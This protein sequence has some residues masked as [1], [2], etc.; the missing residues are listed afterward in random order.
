MSDEL[1]AANARIKELEAALSAESD[2]WKRKAERYLGETLEI[3]DSAQKETDAARRAAAAWKAAAKD[4]RKRWYAGLDEY[5]EL[6][7]TFRA[8]MDEYDKAYNPLIEAYRHEKQRADAAEMERDLLMVTLQEAH[9]DITKSGIFG[10]AMLNTRIR[11]LIDKH[12][13]EKERADAAEALLYEAFLVLQMVAPNA[14]ITDKASDFLARLESRSVGQK[15]SPAGSAV[16]VHAGGVGVVE[17]IEP[18]AAGRPSVDGPYRVIHGTDDLWYVYGRD[19]VPYGGRQAMCY[20]RVQ[21][22]RIAAALNAQ[23]DE[24]RDWERLGMEEFMKGYADTDA[25][26]DASAPQPRATV[27]EYVT[28]KES[29]MGVDLYFDPPDDTPALRKRIRELEDNIVIWHMQL[30]EV[31]LATGPIR[32]RLATLIRRERRL[33]EA[34]EAIA[35]PNPSPVLDY[36]VKHNLEPQPDLWRGMMDIARHALTHRSDP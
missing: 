16:L 9:D 8:K 25:V 21:A 33:E 35:S 31:G 34:L 20:H 12:N 15:E 22:E 32:E 18:Q 19:D 5:K 11:A 24:A 36:Q 26:Y 13:A 27:T 30:A 23:E 7:D 17:E 14:D 29:L 6:A 3:I 1:D 28:G 4:W 2:L 10:Q